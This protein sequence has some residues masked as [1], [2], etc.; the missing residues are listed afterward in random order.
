MGIVYISFFLVFMDRC[1]DF[2]YNSRSKI[3]IVFVGF[4]G[5]RRGVNCL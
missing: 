1:D 3:F 2:R 5:S 4:V